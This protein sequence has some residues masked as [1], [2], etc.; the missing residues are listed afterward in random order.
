MKLAPL[1]AF[2]AAPLLV[3]AGPVSAAKKAPLALPKPTSAAEILK[4]VDDARAPEGEFSFLVRIKDFDGSK[5]LRTNVYKVFCKGD[6]YALIETEAPTRLKGRK[7]LLRGED[8]WLY[9]PSVKRPTR[10]SLQQRLTGEVANGDI[11]R[12]R[13]FD[14]YVAKISGTETLD[15][16]PQLVLVLAAKNDSVTYRKVQLWV[17]PNTFQPSK[18]DFYA[19][20]GKLLKSSLYSE[21]KPALGVPRASKVIIKDALA[22]NKQSHLNYTQYRREKLDESFFTKESLAQ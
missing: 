18:A 11:A 2:F 7:I 6:Q 17:D 22:P 19:I 20:S 13:F 8:L 15:G 14:D 1:I 9:L 10:I 4:R 3:L 16:K 21:F 12:T 5:L